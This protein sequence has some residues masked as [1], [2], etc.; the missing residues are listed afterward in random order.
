M[1]SVSRGM[2]EIHA[3]NIQNVRH[4]QVERA[5]TCSK[6]TAFDAALLRVPSTIAPIELVTCVT[7]N[8]VPGTK[9]LRFFETGAD[10]ASSQ[11]R[12]RLVASR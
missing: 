5:T 2:D 3:S 1:C 4:I 7:P 12:L 11:R 8:L 9:N 6:V 10:V